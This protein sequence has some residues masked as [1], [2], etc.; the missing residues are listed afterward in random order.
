MKKLFDRYIARRARLPFEH[1]P[2][3]WFDLL[4][5]EEQLELQP[6][7]SGLFR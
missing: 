2:A 3:N 1:W 6:M 5:E 4:T 7:V